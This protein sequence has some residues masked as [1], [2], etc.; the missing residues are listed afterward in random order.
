MLPGDPPLSQHFLAGKEEKQN[1]NDNES[2][3][4]ETKQHR[5]TK[6]FV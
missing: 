5:F 2:Y 6:L 1:E 4:L 3:K